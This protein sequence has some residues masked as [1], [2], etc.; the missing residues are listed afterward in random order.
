MTDPLTDI[1]RLATSA[2][3]TGDEKNATMLWAM[4]TQLRDYL[5]THKHICWSCYST[6]V[7][8][9]TPMERKE[10]LHFFVCIDCGY[11]WYE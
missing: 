11:L 2:T 3:R 4:Y 5:A 8:D 10:R 7:A 9:V 6:S 1:Y